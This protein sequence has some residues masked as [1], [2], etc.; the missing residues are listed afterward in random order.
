VVSEFEDYSWDEYVWAYSQVR[1][2]SF[3][4]KIKMVP[5]ADLLNHHHPFN[6][7]V[8]FQNGIYMKAATDILPGEEVAFSYGYPLR[9]DI[10]FTN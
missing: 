1:S 3:G 7:H 6:V 8:Y 9:S 5:I 4:P 10:Y 2:R